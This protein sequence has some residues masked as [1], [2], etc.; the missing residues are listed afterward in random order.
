VAGRGSPALGQGGLGVG[1][2]REQEGGTLLGGR[3]SGLAKAIAC[4][5]S[6]CPCVCTPAC[7]AMLA[8]PPTHVCVR[9]R[10]CACCVSFGARMSACAHLR[11]Q[12]W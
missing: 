3:A 12:I 6:S 9:V 2:G 8:H 5:A 11:S 1:R 4:T 10:V 7:S